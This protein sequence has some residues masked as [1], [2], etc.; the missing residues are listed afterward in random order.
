MC[1]PPVCV[2]AHTQV[3]APAN[4]PPPVWDRPWLRVNV[5][6]SNTSLVLV[7][8]RSVRIRTRITVSRRSGTHEH[9]HERTTLKGIAC[10]LEPTRDRCHQTES[11]SGSQGLGRHMTSVREEFVEQAGARELQGASS[12][13]THRDTNSVSSRKLT[14]SPLTCARDSCVDVPSPGIQDHNSNCPN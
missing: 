13:S 11:N 12:H 7:R 3:R 6:S 8:L 1:H 2:F 10:S 5:A 14:H 4:P 9:F